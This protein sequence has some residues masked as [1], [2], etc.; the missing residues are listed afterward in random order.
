MVFNGNKS[1]A[2]RYDYSS[3]VKEDTNMGC[4]ECQSL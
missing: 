1:N 3:D 4:Y 2:S